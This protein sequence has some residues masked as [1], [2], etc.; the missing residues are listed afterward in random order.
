MSVTFVLC[1]LETTGLSPQRDKIIEIGLVRLVDGVITDS[2]Q[3]LVNPG[4]LLSLKIKRITGITDED[5]VDAPKLPEVLPQ[6]WE[7]IGDHPVAGHN[8]R[9]DLGFL[10]VAKGGP[11]DNKA[12][13]TLELARLLLPLEPSYRLESLCR[14]LNIEQNNAHRALD[15]A[16]AA[17]YLLQELISRLQKLDVQVLMQMSNLLSQSNSA[18]FDFFNGVLGKNL[19]KFPGDKI[20]GKPYWRKKEINEKESSFADFQDDAKE[21]TKKAEESPSQE[22]SQDPDEGFFDTG[23]AATSDA[24][25]A[26]SSTQ[27]SGARKLTQPVAKKTGSDPDEGFFDTGKAATS[28]AKGAYSGTQ[29][30]G[31]RKLTQ[32]VAKKT[33][34]DDYWQPGGPLSSAVPSYE[35][36]PQQEAMA[37]RVADVFRNDKYLLLEAGTGVGKSMAYLIPGVLWSLYNDERVVVA[38]HTI[39]LQ[40]QLW[41]KDVP[42]LRKV[43]KRDFKAA[44]VKGRY[45]YICLRRWSAAIAGRPEEAAFHARV[46][47]WLAQTETG[48]RTELSPLPDEEEFW[49]S[50]C[51]ETENCLGSRCRHR[52][53]CFVIQAR[54]IAEEADLIITNH[55]MLLLDIKSDNM[56]LPEYGPLIMD[57]AHHLEDAA[58]NHLGLR[59]SRTGL[60]MWLNTAGRTLDKLYKTIISFPDAGSLGLEGARK[61]TQ[62][63]AKKTSPDEEQWME[64]VRIATSS[65]QAVHDSARRF[66]ELFGEGMQAVSFAEDTAY[67]TSRITLRLPID[68]API[69]EA[70]AEGTD[71]L[72][73]LGKM[74]DELA[75]L[76]NTLELLSITSDAYLD[77][78]QELKQVG[79]NGSDIA[80]ALNFILDGSEENFVYWADA[81][82]SRDAVLRQCV[83]SAAPVD[84]GEILSERFYQNRKSVIFT[85]ATLSING[86]FNHFIE[87]SGL[88]LLPEEKL[89]TACFD[90]PFDYENQSVLFLHND[91]SV[92]GA[93]S[94]AAYLDDLAAIL[95][96]LL[97][98]TGGRTLVLFTSHMVLRETYYRVQAKLEEH[99]IIILGHGIDGSRNRILEDFKNNPRSAL[100]GASSFWEGVDVQGDSLSCVVM[101]KLPFWSPKIPV[102]EARITALEQQNRNSFMEFSV[103]QAV[104]RFKQGFGRLIRSCNDRG[105]VVV[106][107]NRIIQKRYGRL[108]LQSLPVK[109]HMRGGTELL[110]KKLTGYL[111]GQWTIDDEE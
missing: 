75:K 99:D 111:K 60:S 70:M 46:L 34:L 104:V 14:S 5:L 11:L 97:C 37:R 83:L 4:R 22:E 98:V 87:R 100:F 103:P 85:S 31:A 68:R 39:N 29:L 33:S 80:A 109:Q 64:T 49:L 84:V 18:W 59:V 72:N 40:E 53:D 65:R 41:N 23:K 61:L 76:V 10:A 12:Y 86:S 63:K 1:D 28:D 69:E 62:P 95:V 93:V 77:L 26:Y 43:I 55:S 35:Y 66:F 32:P 56:I 15:D 2:L 78:G 27:L 7:F 50:V 51:G 58:T 8:V 6:V 42:L 79:Q 81:D 105:C 89:E 107:D 21:R 20:S 90:S 108:F 106:L 16:M 45:N 36:R 102:I 13:D 67:Q 25:G 17:A 30:S 82:F 57:E 52:Y 24:K 88:S 19:I 73:L 91:I 3:T 71:L 38:T 74:L 92:Q 54:R 101:V 44:L 47:S 48:D 9:F 96:D 110:T 94:Q